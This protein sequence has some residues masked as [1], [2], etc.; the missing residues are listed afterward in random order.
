MSV[1]ALPSCSWHFG[2]EVSHDG[3]RSSLQWVLKRNCSI[4]PRQLGTVYLSLCMLAVVI[5]AGFWMQG[6]PVV[7]LFAAIELICV[8]TALLVYAHHAGDREVLTL[9]GRELAVETRQGSRTQHLNFGA[10]WLVVEPCA[11]QGSLVEL[12]GR[13]QTVRVG[14][15]LRPEMRAAFANE[16]RRALRRAGSPEHTT[17]YE[18]T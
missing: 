10:D 17:G 5:S 11:G 14:R 4:T 15:F 8:G 6:A 12:S 16:L 3:Q 1:S 7:T 18:L 9:A 13:G 2:C